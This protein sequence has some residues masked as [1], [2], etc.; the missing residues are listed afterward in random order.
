[1]AYKITNSLTC[2]SSFMGIWKLLV[3]T[4]FSLCFTREKEKL[5]EEVAARRQKK[6]IVRHARHQFLEA[7]ALR[8]LE[9]LQE[10]DRFSFFCWKF[11]ESS[12]I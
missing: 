11:I 12:N 2:I 10:L 7:A 6:L 1:M 4:I 9:L 8:E 3:I 5:R